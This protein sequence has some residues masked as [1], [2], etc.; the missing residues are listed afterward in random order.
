MRSLSVSYLAPIR[1]T[2]Q[3]GVHF[4]FD[5]FGRSSAQYGFRFLSEDGNVVYAEGTRTIVRLDPETL[6]P[7]RWTDAIRQVALSA[8]TGLNS[9][10][11]DARKIDCSTIMEGRPVLAEERGNP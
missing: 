2:G 6:R 10:I 5:Y 9:R 11:P 4:W 1:G 3:V 8:G 7:A